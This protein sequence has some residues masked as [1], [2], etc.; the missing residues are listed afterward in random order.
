MQEVSRWSMR[1]ST[2]SEPLSGWIPH[3][4]NN[5]SSVIRN[6]IKKNIYK[7]FCRNKILV[8]TTKFYR[9]TIIKRKFWC[10]TKR[11]NVIIITRPI[12]FL[13]F[14]ILIYIDQACCEI[15]NYY[16][17]LFCFCALIW[18]WDLV[19]STGVW[20][21]SFT[22]GVSFFCWWVYDRSFALWMDFSFFS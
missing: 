7:K 15:W 4:F 14:F 19:Y 18:L 21:I 11:E 3:V 8:W 9:K 20:V 13:C 2:R 5:F 22:D 17:C 6:N 12:Y 1:I 16:F 10:R